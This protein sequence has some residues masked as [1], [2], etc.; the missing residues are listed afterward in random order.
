M[1]DE[2]YRKRKEHGLCVRCGKVPPALERVMCAECL[3]EAKR[4][5]RENR[6][7]FKKLGI[8]P[9]CGQ[10]KL[11]GDEKECPECS[12]KRYAENRKSAEKRKGKYKEYYKLRTEALKKDGIC[13]G[14]G[15]RKSESGKT[16]CGICLAK[17]RERY[18]IDR[19]KSG[20]DAIDRSERRGYGL[21]YC[22]G[23][24]LDRYGGLCKKCAKTIAGNLP[25]TTDNE[26]WRNDNKLLRGKN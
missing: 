1:G 21:C 9:I 20:K 24:F 25:K 5:T 4:K 12:A 15:K 26:Y 8:C 22:C 14:C 6:E 2:T 16:Y 10:N 23:N 18:R 17:K 7:F 11:M 19:I 13:R 3:E